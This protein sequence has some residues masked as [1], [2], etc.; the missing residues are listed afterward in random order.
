[1]INF[2]FINNLNLWMVNLEI[3]NLTYKLFNNCYF[4]AIIYFISLNLLCCNFL[5]CIKIC[6]NSAWRFSD[7]TKRYNV[8]VCNSIPGTQ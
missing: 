8:S 5:M 2:N 1:M 4:K 6:V 7:C 3:L